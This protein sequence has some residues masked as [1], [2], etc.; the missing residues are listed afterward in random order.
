MPQ[1]T[2]GLSL[3]DYLISIYLEY[4]QIVLFILYPATSRKVDNKKQKEPQS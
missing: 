4:Y 2:V 3:I 1:C